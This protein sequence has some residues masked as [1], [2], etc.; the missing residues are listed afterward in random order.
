MNIL[1]I[2]PYAGS[3][4]LV[5]MTEEMVRWFT[6]CAKE[7]I[8]EGQ[9]RIVAINNAAD[10]QI[11]TAL[12]DWHGYNDTNEGFGR[13]VNLAIMRELRPSDSHVLVLNN[14]LE[15]PDT[16]WLEKLLE[17]REGEL[18]LSPC[19]DVTATK[20]AVAE[21]ARDIEPFRSVQVSAFCWLVPTS[22]IRKLKKKFGFPLFHPDFTNYGSD[23]VTA[24]CL[25]S[26]LSKPF[27]V[28]PRSWVRHKKA[29]TA[30]EL[31]VKAG[32]PELLR[33]IANFKRARKLT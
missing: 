21:G 28:V 11:P 15:F 24:A 7:R 16:S 5:R 31:G 6:V 26:F 2:V 20:E 12:V 32:E 33:R 8:D 14:D 27:K 1:A 3:K 13:A 30:N 29:Q 25:R 4:K 17:A 9:L 10:G 22:I 18:V 23:D 19:T